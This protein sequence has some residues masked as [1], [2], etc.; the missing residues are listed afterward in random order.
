VKNQPLRMIVDIFKKSALDVWEEALYLIIFNVIWFLGA[1]LILPLPFLTFALF[2]TVYDI[3][4]GKGVKFGAFFEYG[5]QM[6]KQAYTWGVI[7]LGVFVLAWINISFYRQIAAQWAAVIQM[8]IIAMTVFWAILQLVSLPMYP[9]LKEPGFRLALR[10]AAA[11]V[12]LQ[13]LAIFS[14]IVIVG[15]VGIITLFF[16]AIVFLAAISIIAVTANRTVEEVLQRVMNKKEET[17]IQEE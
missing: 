3:S 17:E 15:L 8:V 5:R 7:N 14:L 11:V 1:L 2:F 4:Q 10:N 13:P 12:G 6:W 9:R 16:Q